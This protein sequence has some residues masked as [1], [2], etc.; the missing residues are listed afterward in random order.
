M[1]E[2][3]KGRRNILQMLNDNELM[4]RYTLDLAGIKFLVNFIPKLRPHN[5]AVMPEMKVVTTWRHLATESNSA[6]VKSLGL[7]QPSISWEYSQ[8]LWIRPPG[9]LPL[10]ADFNSC[11][12]LRAYVTV[13]VRCKKITDDS[14]NENCS[15]LL[16]FPHDVA[17]ERVENTLVS[18]LK[19]VVQDLHVFAA[20]HL[21]GVSALLSCWQFLLPHL[22]QRSHKKQV[23]YSK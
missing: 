6:A 11:K 18:Q 7:L 8:C 14:N 20:F 16:P 21:S 23:L 1:A 19:R 9:S 17:V 3:Q 13:Q 22:K 2:W 15:R 10:I 4:K 12:C 5:N